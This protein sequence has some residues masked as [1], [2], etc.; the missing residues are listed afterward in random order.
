MYKDYTTYTNHPPLY[1]R[2]H[3]AVAAKPVVPVDDGSNTP[4]F[5]GG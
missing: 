5:D 2:I 1:F 4:D 3:G